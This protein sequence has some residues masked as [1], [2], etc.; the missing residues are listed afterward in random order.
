MN[1]PLRLHL[2]KLRTL[3]S[4]Q[5]QSVQGRGD[6]K[7]VDLDEIPGDRKITRSAGFGMGGV[8]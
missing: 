3:S 7:V 2:E 1:R 6:D 4:A 5:A 8:K